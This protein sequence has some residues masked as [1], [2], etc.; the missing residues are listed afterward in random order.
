MLAVILV[1]HYGGIVGFGLLSAN[2]IKY[3]VDMAFIGKV[4]IF[5]G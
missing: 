3:E 4:A 1:F 5:R 2:L